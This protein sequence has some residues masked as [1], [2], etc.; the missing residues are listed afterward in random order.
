MTL[1]GAT[2]VTM[3]PMDPIGLVRTPFTATSQIPKGRSAHHDAEGVI[4]VR[5]DLEEGL[6][7]IDG[8]SHLYVLWVFD[9]AGACELSG[10]PPTDTLSPSGNCRASTSQLDLM[11]PDQSQPP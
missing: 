10:V 8:F 1:G 11:S 3:L 9:R 7:D 4:E 6:G 5:P 2:L